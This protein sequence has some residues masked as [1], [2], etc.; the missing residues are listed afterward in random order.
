MNR[1]TLGINDLEVHMDDYHSNLNYELAPADARS[2]TA[3]VHRL[4]VR[5]RMRPREVKFVLVSTIAAPLLDS[6]ILSVLSI[7]HK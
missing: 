2:T 3:R 4:I 5:R 7:G 6:L 1:C